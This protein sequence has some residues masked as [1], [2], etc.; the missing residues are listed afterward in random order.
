MTVPQYPMTRQTGCPF[1]PPLQLGELREQGGLSRVQLW[2][3]EPVW[4]ATSYEDVRVVLSDPAFS[5]DI[6]KPGFPT[7]G[8]GV[9][10]HRRRHRNF[11]NLD[12]PQHQVQRRMV[13]KY[14][15][16]R[17]VEAMR[18]GIERIVDE[19]LT[20]FAQTPQPADFVHGVALPIT[21]RI[22][23]QLL[24]VPYED[25]EL[26]QSRTMMLTN[27]ELSPEEALDAYE[28][29]RSYLSTL[30]QNKRDNPGDDVT[31]ELVELNTQGRLNEDEML[32]TLRLLLSAGHETTASM[33][34]LGTLALLENPAQTAQLR[35]DP[36][37]EH[38]AAVV[39]ELMR[40][41][42]ITHFGRRRVAVTDVNV[43]EQRVRAG[44]GVV[45]ATDEANRD[46]AA[47]EDPN[48]FDVTRDARHHLGFG[49]GVHQC[50]G[51]PLARLELKIVYPAVFRHLPNLQVAS[52]VDTLHFKTQQIFYGLYALPVT[53]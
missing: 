49:F 52:P 19:V 21:S 41:L 18:P 42:T 46:P 17:R 5:A 7:H 9:A 51:Q 34:A 37:E 36:S 25:H 6:S 35:D 30:V 3:G 38:T 15:S 28:D 23:G 13:S 2:N 26:F 12:D 22:I 33:I 10:A 44:D 45:A 8:E 27:S 16:L 32:N 53:W 11:L 1:D 50:L 31:T 4:L 20:E 24:G 29:L 48:T 14:F 40:Y 47:F 43:G 39:E